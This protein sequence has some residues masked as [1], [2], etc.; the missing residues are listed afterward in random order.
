MDFT[1]SIAPS[2]SNIISLGLLMF[3]TVEH[4]QPA[5]EYKQ[6]LKY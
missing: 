3:R 6:E 2:T 1:S 5:T 4:V